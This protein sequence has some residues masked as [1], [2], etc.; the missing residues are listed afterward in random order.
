MLRSITHTV[1]LVSIIFGVIGCGKPGD[2]SIRG[3]DF[4][5]AMAVLA[6]CPSGYMGNPQGISLSGEECPADI[7]S[8]ELAQAISPMVFGVDCKRKIITIRSLDRV[9]DTAW[10][11]MPDN[12]FWV[13]FEGYTWKFISPNSAGT[14]CETKMLT[15]VWGRVSCPSIESDQADIQIELSFSPKSSAGCSFIKQPCKIRSAAKLKQCG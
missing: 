7:P 9:I 12:S 1:A 8:F 15:D 5:G 10:E 11:L 6:Q 4:D 3:A 14:S 13:G 2:N